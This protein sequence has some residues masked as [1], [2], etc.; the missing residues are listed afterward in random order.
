MREPSKHAAPESL[1]PNRLVRPRLRSFR[2]RAGAA[3]WVTA[4]LLVVTDPAWAQATA[5]EPDATSPPA[6]AAPDVAPPTGAAAPLPPADV[7]AAE[8]APAVAPP[9]GAAAPLPPADVPAAPA[10]AA[11]PAPPTAPA[12]P[13]APAPPTAPAPAPASP[14]RLERDELPIPGYV[15]G[16][17]QNVALGMSPYSPRT[18]GLPGGMTAGFGAAL[19]L[20]GW[21]FKW[22]GF[23]TASLQFSIDERR[24]PTDE[25]RTTVFHTPPA[26]IDNWGQ[27]V[28]TSTVPGNWV[29][30]TFYYGNSLVGATVS[31]DTWNPTQPTTYYQ[32]GSQYFINNAFVTYTPEALGK[33]RLRFQVGR[34]STN[35]GQLGRWGNGLYTNAISGGPRGDGELTRAELAVGRTVSL[36][37]EHGLM[38]TREGT[39]PAQV[40]RGPMNGWRRPLWAATF[41]HHAHLGFVVKGAF[42]TTFQAHYMTSFTQEDRSESLVDNPGTQA[43]NEED[44]EDGRLTVYG[45]DV[46]VMHD[47][48]GFLGVGVAYVDGH[49]A[50]PLKGLYTYGGEGEQV[51]ERWWGVPSGGSGSILV[52]GFN[53]N[54]SI[55]KLVN[56][57]GTF[58]GDGPDIVINAGLHIARIWSEFEPYDGQSRHKYGLD[59]LYTFHRYMGVGLRGDRVSPNSDDSGEAF[60]VLSPRLVFR[61]NY[62]SHEMVQLIY[63][64]WFY[65]PRTRNEG[66]GL[67]TPERLDDQMV[68]LN[69][70]M[71]W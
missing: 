65:G 47:A 63:A 1:E 9:A 25:Q 67:R 4:A 31:V 22:S 13:I 55:G 37:A 42:E 12:P 17:R 3:P 64:K 62:N 6:G 28:S 57:P 7:P 45:A 5:G 30:N 10:P 59:A 33:L 46:R 50:Y 56:Y 35:Y 21:T 2:L 53:Y 39:P 18:P 15:P 43:V 11:A 71:W 19:P 23:M 38:G 14:P 20:Q 36:T 41:M 24:Y 26:T 8:P 40:V 69:F 29:G 51:V 70:N 54:F 27:F 16:Y 34:F 44:V 66:T 52:G 68:A 49:D 61:S 60:E 32:V 48:F 58:V